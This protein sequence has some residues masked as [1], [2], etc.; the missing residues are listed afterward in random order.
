MHGHLNV[1][2]IK[3]YLYGERNNKIKSNKMYILKLMYKAIASD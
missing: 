2:Q 3:T 1:K